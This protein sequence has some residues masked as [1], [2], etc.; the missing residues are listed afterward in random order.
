MTT[1][2]I[3]SF[4]E[5]DGLGLHR[6][7]PSLAGREDRILESLGLTNRVLAVLF[8]INLEASA[9]CSEIEFALVMNH[10]TAANAMQELLQMAAVENVS[11]PRG[12]MGAVRI[13]AEGAKILQDGLKLWRKAKASYNTSDASSNKTSEEHTSTK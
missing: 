10:Q 8:F 9:T 12:Q 1:L 5:Q 4:E 3:Y 6:A 2:R 13:T 7:D 11:G